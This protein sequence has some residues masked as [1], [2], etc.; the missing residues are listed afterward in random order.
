MNWKL[1]L[2]RDWRRWF[3]SITLVAGSAVLTLQVLWL[4]YLIRYGW[5]A[6]LS[7]AQLAAITDIAINSQLTLGLVLVAF[8]MVIVVQSF[9]ASF[10]KTGVSVEA[11]GYEEDEETPARP[12]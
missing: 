8:S 12:D 9:R 7:A 6:S 2:S 4:T 3:V 5:P 11:E 10:G 1:L